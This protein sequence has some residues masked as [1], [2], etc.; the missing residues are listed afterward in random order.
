MSNTDQPRLARLW[1]PR[2]GEGRRVQTA[3]IE[4]TPIAVGLE[5][6]TARCRADEIVLQRAL[7]LAGLAERA[8]SVPDQRPT[9]RT[10]RLVNFAIRYEIDG[11]TLTLRYPRGPLAP[12]H[13]PRA[14]RLRE[15][16]RHPDRLWVDILIR[17]PDARATELQLPVDFALLDPE[18]RSPGTFQVIVDPS[19]RGMTTEVLARLIEDAC[20]RARDDDPES[21]H[22][23]FARF[24]EAARET[25][26]RL[27]LG[28]REAVERRIERTARERGIGQKV[29]EALA[30]FLEPGDEV[31]IRG[32][33]PGAEPEVTVRLDGTPPCA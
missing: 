17:E 31:R 7:H 1:D 22:R 8:I 10:R 23:Q 18:T 3:L 28:W 12:R 21:P 29:Q 33:A 16:P 4:G 20:W 5:E 9:P 25:A 30:G 13:L 24:Q 2:G 32:A 15:G 19:R 14:G 27:L 26:D 11:E 6:R